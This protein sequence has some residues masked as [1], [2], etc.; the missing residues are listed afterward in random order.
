MR[1]HL[2]IVLIVG[3]TA[4]SGAQSVPFDPRGAI[5]FDFED[6][7]ALAKWDTRELTDLKLT[8]DWRASGRSAAAI[9]IHQWSEGKQRWPAVIAYRSRGALAI[10]DFSAFEFLRFEIHNPQEAPVPVTLHLRDGE[11]KRFSQGA[12]VPARSTESFSIPIESI[13]VALDPKDIAELHFYASHPKSTYTFYVDDV[14]LCI[15]ALG[16]ARKL[17]ANTQRLERDAAVALGPVADIASSELRTQVGQV[18]R[19]AEQAGARLSQLESEDAGSWDEMRRARESTRV[20]EREHLRLAGLV[21]CLQVLAQARREEA[22]KFLLATEDSMQKV[23]L[24]ATRFESPRAHRHTLELAR[25]EHE[26][27]QV[28]AF[29]FNGALRDV[30]WEVTP[31]EGPGGNRLQPSV[32]LVGYVNC[33]QPPYPVSRTGWWPDPLLGFQTTVREVPL[34]EVLSLWV[35]VET[36]DRTPAGSYRGAFSVTARDAEAQTLDVQVNVWDF[37][38]PRH[39]RL[40][41]A[42]SFRG[43]SAKLYPAEKTAEMTRKYEDWLL[44]QYHLNPG[45]IYAGGPPPWDVDRLGELMSMGLNAINLGIFA[46]RDFDENLT[47]F[48]HDSDVLR[49]ER[50]RVAAAILALSPATRER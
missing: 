11:Q 12:H 6:E 38:L 37:A 20:L 13:A 25:N 43:L 28:L 5:L 22:D 39:T 33:K 30:R 1:N 48:T 18:R 29:P 42:L 47:S 15:D 2:L 10:T 50:R 35:T 7:A 16:A 41:T 31:F 24:E 26:S 14:R 17:R 27:F 44:G 8:Q 40:R 49:A 34:G 32:R 4:R 3:F 46:G 19:L 23:F 21:P 36:S 9:T 45:S